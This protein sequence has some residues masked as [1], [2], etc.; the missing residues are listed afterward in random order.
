MNESSSLIK[1]LEWE[2]LLELASIETNRTNGPTNPYSQKRLFGKEEKDI[3]VTLYRDH[4]AWCPYCQKI[5]LWL[6]WKRIPYFTKKVTMRCYG[7]K[8]KWYLEKVASGILPAIEIDNILYTESDQILVELEKRFGPLG[9]QI[10][11]ERIIEERRLERRL[12]RAWCSWLCQPVLFKNQEVVRQKKFQDLAREMEC[13]IQAN[14]NSLLDIDDKSKEI[15]LPGTLDIIFIPYLERMNASLAFY[16]GFNLRKEHP[17]INSWLTELEKDSVYRG[18][19]G[20]FHTHAH[21]LPPQMGGCFYSKNKQQIDF[22]NAIDIGDGLGQMETSVSE[23]EL[24]KEKKPEAIALERVIRHKDKI[25]HVNIINSDHFDQPLRAALTSLITNRLCKPNKGSAKGLRY[26]RDRI[27][28][29][30][31]MPLLS[32]RKL[33]KALERTASLD[34]QEVGIPI[35]TNNRLDQD[36]KPFIA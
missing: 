1:E 16:K 10:L 31:D 28:V 15:K 8:E 4:H 20:D 11:D 21:D 33:R 22:S 35:P 3:R 30:R 6:E 24:Q 26:L 36:P 2:N 29:P 32:A 23:E 25:K 9:H 34:S 19:Q 27:S 5:W 18:T 12:F 7:S 14:K 17:Y 13:I